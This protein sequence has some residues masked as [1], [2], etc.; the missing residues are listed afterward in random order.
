MREF[1]GQTLL[2]YVILI[3]I[4]TAALVAM[5]PYMKCGIQSIV[6]VTADQLGQQN[7]ADQKIDATSAYLVNTFLSSKISQEKMA[8]EW[9]GGGTS[10]TYDDNT[11][12]ESTSLTNLGLTDR[13]R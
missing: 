3:G 10:Y 7:E 5:A 8:R 13:A 12:V 11:N 2:E 9:V 4:I 1:R 6:K